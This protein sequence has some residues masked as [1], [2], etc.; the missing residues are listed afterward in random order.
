MSKAFGLAGLRVGIALGP[1]PLIGE[2][3]KSRGPY[4]VNA[5]AEKAAAAA[6]REDAD[7]LRETVAEAVAARR[8]LERALADLGLRVFPSVS[9]FVLVAAPNG[10]AA[11]F[12]RELAEAG[13]GVR[14]FP[15]LPHAGDCVRITVGP[16]ALME[17]LVSRAREIINQ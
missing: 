17:R 1:A 14:P 16:A 7:W 6:L 10:D 3:E 9:N 13:L 5:A 15:A 12:S 4:K 2:I 11:H 8:N